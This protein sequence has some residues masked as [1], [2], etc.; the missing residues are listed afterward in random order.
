[1]KNKTFYEDQVHLW[2]ALGF[3]SD[4]YLQYVFLTF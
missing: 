1:M 2:L 3:L 4:G